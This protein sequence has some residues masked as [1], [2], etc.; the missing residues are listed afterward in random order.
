[1]HD[2]LKDIGDFIFVSDAPAKAGAIMVAGG[3][4]PELPELAAALWKAGYAPYVFIGGRYSVKLGRFP[5]PQSGADAYG[6]SYE[7]EYEFYR[8]VLLKNGVPAEAIAGEDRSTYTKENALFA[9]EAADAMG[10][11]LSRI[12]LVCKSFHARRCLVY[13][14]SAFPGADIRVI[15]HDGFGISK[16]NW[17]L[18]EYGLKRVLGELRRCGEQ[19]TA[20]DLGISAQSC[21]AASGVD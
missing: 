19:F 10:L 11:S 1:M 3:S 9:R 13:Y 16:E 14:Q 5:G 7:T 21:M 6:G 20:E 4:R 15:P 18:S 8:D 17:F 12:L 2:V